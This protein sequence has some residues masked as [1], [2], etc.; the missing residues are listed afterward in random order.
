M[1]GPQFLLT[2]LQYFLEQWKGQVIATSDQVTFCETAHD[3]ERARV[4]CSQP[5]LMHLQRF[6]EGEEPDHSGPTYA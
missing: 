1:I 4:V 3:D 2:A 5:G 6:R